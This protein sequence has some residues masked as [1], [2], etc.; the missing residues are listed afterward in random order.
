MVSEQAILP[1]D[2]ARK[3]SIDSLYCRLLEDTKLPATTVSDKLD[4]HSHDY[5]Y[6]DLGGYCDCDECLQIRTSGTT[7][8]QQSQHPVK[9]PSINCNPPESSRP[10]RFFDQVQSL[11]KAETRIKSTLKT[12]NQRIDRVMTLYEQ[13][14]LDPT[15][16]QLEPIIPGEYGCR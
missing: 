1:D 6:H 4:S 9:I 11:T 14:L 5:S 8:T 16:L 12:L 7:W 15:A 13:T 3:F 10:G 2:D